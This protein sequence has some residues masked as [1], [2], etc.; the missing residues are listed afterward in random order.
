[1]QERTNSINGTFQIF[2]EI[3][4]GT[5]VVLSLPLS[6]NLLKDDAEK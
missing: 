1:M 5:E 4:Q 2:S 6:E 3:E